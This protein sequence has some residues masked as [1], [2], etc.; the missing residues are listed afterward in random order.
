MSAATKISLSLPLDDVL[1]LNE[2]T[3]SG[4]Y[5][6]RSA[7]VANA[8]KIMRSQ[9]LTDSYVT[10]FDEWATS[11]EAALWDATSADGLGQG[12]TGPDHAGQSGRGVDA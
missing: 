3:S 10:A 8:I 5:P 11:G 6:T 7:V 4:R 2:Q 9:E 1:F 12:P